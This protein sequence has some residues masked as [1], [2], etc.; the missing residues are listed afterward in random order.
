MA[1][2]EKYKVVRDELENLRCLI[3]ECNFGIVINVS[4]AELLKHFRVCHRKDI[5]FSSPCLFSKNCFHSQ[6]FKSYDTLYKHL[7]LYHAGF[8]Q[9]EEQ[10]L[11]EGADHVP[12]DNDMFIQD[13]GTYTFLFLQ[14]FVLQ[15]FFSGNL[16]QQHQNVAEGYLEHVALLGDAQPQPDDAPV[17]PNMD[18]G[19]VLLTEIVLINN[20]FL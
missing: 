17:Y 5:Q 8:F 14:Y 3:G 19:K 12:P 7:R 16:H 13:E 10:Q 20:L 1:N 6:P 9:I 11:V 4:A 15:I 2:F 18:T